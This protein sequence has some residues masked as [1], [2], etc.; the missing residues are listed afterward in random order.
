MWGGILGNN[1]ILVGG[2]ASYSCIISKNITSGCISSLNNAL[3]SNNIFLGFGGVTG[4]ITPSC[5]NLTVVNNFLEMSSSGAPTFSPLSSIIKNNISTF[6]IPQNG[7]NTYQ[8]NYIETSANTFVNW[9]GGD[10]HLKPTSVGVNAGT[11]G[12]DIGIYGTAQP[13]KA[14]QTTAYPQIPS[15]NVAP[16]TDQGKLKVNITIE[17]QDR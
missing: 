6:A 14:S 13:Y 10:Y 15:A 5:N 3:I 8:N 17:A 4:R 2:S 11:D 7:T 16:E 12:T 9:G 1:S